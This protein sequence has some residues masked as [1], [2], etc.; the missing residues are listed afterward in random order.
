LLRQ[1]HRRLRALDL[2]LPAQL[3][4]RQIAQRLEQHWGEAARPVCD[5]LLQFEHWRYG[6]LSDA[7]ALRLLQTQSK[8]LV[9][10]QRHAPGKARPQRQPKP[11]S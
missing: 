10:P 11:H 8:T 5:W 7:A 4:P 3:P 2:P 9:W 1:L 6:P